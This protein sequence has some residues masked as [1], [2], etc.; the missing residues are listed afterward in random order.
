MN[1]ATF[2]FR[3]PSFT[4][5]VP[6]AFQ[7]G[8]SPVTLLGPDCDGFRPN[9]TVLT[10]RMPTVTFEQF[11]AQADSEAANLRGGRVLESGEETRG[12]HRYGRLVYRYRHEGNLLRVKSLFVKRG[13]LFHRLLFTAPDGEYERLLPHAERMMGSFELV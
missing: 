1:D 10:F 7:D 3:H 4:F 12:G 8:T 11:Q 9:L 6:E 5:Q 2:A 13:D